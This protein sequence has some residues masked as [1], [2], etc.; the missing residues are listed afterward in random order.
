MVDARKKSHQI[1]YKSAYRVR[2]PYSQLSKLKPQSRRISWLLII[3][4]HFLNGILSF[5]NK[6]FGFLPS[7]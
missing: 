4:L 7:S 6:L 3:K 1:G 2:T 5:I